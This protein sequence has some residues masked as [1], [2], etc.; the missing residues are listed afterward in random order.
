MIGEVK[1]VDVVVPGGDIG[2][3]IRVRVKVDIRKAIHRFLHV[4]V[5]GD[6]QE[7]VMLLRYER[8]PNHCFRCRKLR[9]STRECPEGLRN[10]ETPAGDLPFGA[11][12]KATPSDHWASIRVRQ[13][14][15]FSNQQA[16]RSDEDWVRGVVTKMRE[17]GAEKEETLMYRIQRSK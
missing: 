10:P 1:D 11:W 5:L 16:N 14:E 4:D 17:I 8:L 13:K 7:I 6:G 9:R 15:V 12:M 3:F 2:K